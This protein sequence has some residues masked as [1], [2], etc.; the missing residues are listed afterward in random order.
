L[1]VAWETCSAIHV[2]FEDNSGNA[3]RLS[4]LQREWYGN[5]LMKLKSEMRT[6][7]G[8]FNCQKQSLGC[9]ENFIKL[10]RTH[11]DKIQGANIKLIIS[12]WAWK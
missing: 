9:A 8:Y 7:Y 11:F 3:T 6:N 5:D 2:H 1:I 12:K 10:K 4:V